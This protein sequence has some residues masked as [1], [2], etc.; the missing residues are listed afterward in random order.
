MRSACELVHSPVA[1]HAMT[2]RARRRIP[3]ATVARLPV[4]LRSLLEIAGDATTV[5]SERLAELAGVNAAKVRKDL[6][7]LGSYGTRGVG[8]R[9][10]V[11]AVPD[12][13]RAG[14]HPALAGRHRRHRQP[15]RT[16]SPTTAASAPAASTSSPWS[17]P[18]RPR[19]ASRSAGSEIRPLD[20]PATRSSGP[21]SIAIGIIAT[22]ADRRP[23]R[24][25]PAGR[26]R[27][28]VDPQLR[29]GRAHRP[30]GR[31][32]AQ[33]RPRRRAADPELPPAA[34]GRGEPGRRRSRRRGRRPR[35]L[36]HRRLTASRMP[37]DEPLYPVNLRLAR[38][39]AASSS[40]AARWRWARCADCSRRSAAV[41]GGGAR[42]G[43]RARRAAARRTAWPSSAAAT[44]GA[45]RRATG[46][47]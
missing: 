14:A 9:R 36:R 41:H 22:P 5:S 12:E 17:T 33:G 26:R 24:R 28:H 16:P 37:V 18:T 34:A 10:R 3:E 15:R 38:R 47:S 25:R 11:P 8:L 1:S 20:R 43:R 29:A 44:N 23:G 46:W 40:A 39:R 32:A 13:P 35:S 27:H 19:S 45:R 31:V 2:E 6:S 42:G 30:E 7:Y 4:Y 21:T